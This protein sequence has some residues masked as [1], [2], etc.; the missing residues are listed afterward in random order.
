[1]QLIVWLWNPW[2]KYTFTRHN[3]GFMFVDFL[4]KKEQFSDWKYES[5][6]KSEISTGVLSWEKILLVKPQTFMNLSGE[7]VEKIC[8]F[9]KLKNSDFIVIYDDKD[10]DFGKI[11][12]RETGSAGGHNGV[13]D[14]IRYFWNDWKRIKVWVGKTPEKF[15]TA[16]WVLSNFNEEER[17]DIEN[18][19]LV[20]TF[21]ELEKII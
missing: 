21:Q 6:F 5:K 15:D 18:E 14:I 10:M 13:K 17:I 2:E 20:K 9:Y 16:D 1:M 4:H 12:V 7:A 11:R 8:Q 3:I 19:V